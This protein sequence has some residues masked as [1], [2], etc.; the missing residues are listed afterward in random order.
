MALASGTQFGPYTIMD[1]LGR[2][3]MASVYKA[4]EVALDRY[5]AL[6]VLPGEF[7]HDESFA[8]RFRRE[9]KVIAKLEHPHIIPIHAFGIEKGIPWMAMRMIAGGAL[10]AVLKSTRVSPERS[11]AIL[12][13]VADALDYAHSKGVVHRDVKPQNILLDEHDRVYLA[14]F[15]IA[16]MLEGSQG[17]TQTGMITGTPQYMAPEQATGQTIDHRA[18]IYALGVVAYEMLTGRV[19]FSADTPVAVLMKQVSDP[20]PIPAAGEVPEPMVRA[21]LKAL[22]KKAEERWNT[23]NDFVKAL[24]L[25][26]SLASSTAETV[27]GVPPMRV[28][29]RPPSPPLPPTR[30]AGRPPTGSSG[31]GLAIGVALGVGVLGLIAVAA[32]AYFFYFRAESN[33]A[34]VVPPTTLAVVPS[35]SPTSAPAL[36]PPSVSPVSPS[37]APNTP[38]PVPDTTTPPARVSPPPAGVF[39]PVNPSPASGRA[40]TP[41][42]APPSTTLA[43]TPPTLPAPPTTAVATPA[44]VV[45]TTVPAPSNG[46]PRLERTLPFELD[47]PAALNVVVGSVRVGT[48]KVVNVDAG[49]PGRKPNDKDKLAFTVDLEVP[50]GAGEWD[51][52]MK[53]SLFDD[54][55]RPLAEFDSGTSLEGEQKTHKFS[56]GI[57]PTMLEQVRSIRIRFEADK[58]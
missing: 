6:K 1:P 26:L 5:V 20:I 9:A 35:T 27:G 37:V 44:P 10:S 25:G 2:G 46:S 57:H 39:T 53:I 47:R 50:K 56:Y 34:D 12:R 48:L 43:Q 28:P 45:P 11:V 32:L 52:K 4:Y 42:V 13:G 19:P 17:L 18:D 49:K 22:H 38:P 40:T 29:P 55:G 23:A 24:E 3:G 7:M 31:A 58:D 51:F 33:V 8:E 14:D 36:G 21:L 30:P 54:K 16:K 15:G 41:A